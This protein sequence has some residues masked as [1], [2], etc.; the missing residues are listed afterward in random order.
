MAKTITTPKPGLPKTIFL[1]CADQDIK[2]RP[3]SMEH[4]QNLM[5]EQARLKV[6]H[7]TLSE[8]QNLKL[9]NGKIV[10]GSDSGKAEDQPAQ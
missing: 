10:E 8:G 5:D 1:D 2:K 6:N 7:W 9:E 4:A 3:Y